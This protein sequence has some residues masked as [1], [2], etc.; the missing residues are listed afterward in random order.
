LTI[1]LG[2]EGTN[3]ET[4]L[5]RIPKTWDDLL[6]SSYNV[7]WHD[8]WKKNQTK[9]DVGFMW[10]LYHMVIAINSWR[11]QMCEDMK[12]KCPM[13]DLVTPKPLAHRFYDYPR[14]RLT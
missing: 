8:V 6:S 7:K 4:M 14:A 3:R 11:P 12:I 13:C 1:V 2:K 5:Q 9:K 10:T